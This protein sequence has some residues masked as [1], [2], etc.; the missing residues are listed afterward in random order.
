M[1]PP[2]HFERETNFA[3]YRQSGSFYFLFFERKQ[4]IEIK[5]NFRNEERN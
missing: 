2:I 5:I 3:T 4:N 1:P